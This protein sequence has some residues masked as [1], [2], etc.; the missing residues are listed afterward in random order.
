VVAIEHKMEGLL[1]GKRLLLPWTICTLLAAVVA[2]ILFEVPKYYRLYTS[3]VAVTGRIIDLQPE[4]HGSVIYAYQVG[5]RSYEGGGHAGDIHSHFDDLRVGQ[6]VP[7]V[8]DP[9][10]E[11][12]SC[13]GEPLKHLRSLLMLTAFLASSPTL[14][15][16]ALKV[17]QFL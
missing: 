1:R 13:L 5:G 16:L 3:G 9:H 11:E 12:V 6:E 15:L 8:F 17:R 14:L 2:A 7:V 4:N 10:K